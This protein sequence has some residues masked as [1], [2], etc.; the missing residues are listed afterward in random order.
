MKTLGQNSVEIN[1]QAHSSRARLLHMRLCGFI[2]PGQQRSVSV[3][4]LTEYAFGNVE[5]ADT[6]RRQYGD[7]RKAMSAF[8]ELGWETHGDDRKGGKQVFS[9][10][11][12]KLNKAKSQAK[13]NLTSTG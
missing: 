9:I 13:S 11:R 5:S 1:K 6:R 8:I 10:T 3:E 12:P 7:I 4:K 2:D